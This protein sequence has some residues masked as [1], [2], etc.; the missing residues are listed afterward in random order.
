MTA[1]PASAG[2]AALAADPAQHGRQ[3]SIDFGQS[4]MPGLAEF[5]AG[6]NGEAVEAVRQVCR[7][8]AA[9]TRRRRQC[10][11]LWGPTGTGKTHLLRAVCMALH[12][13]GLP[14]AY[15]E[16]GATLPRPE[17]LREWASHVLLC[18]DGLDRIACNRDWEIALYDLYE[19][20]RE[21]NHVLLAA[22][23]RA[24]ADLP[25]CLPDLAS[26]LGWGLVYRLK[27]LETDGERLEALM[28][29]AR[30]YAFTLPDDVAHYL[31][32]RFPRDMHTLCGLLE[33]ID[34]ASLASGQRVTLRA[35]RAYLAGQS[36]ACSQAERTMGT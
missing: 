12:R 20:T 36:E 13:A 18:I 28:L 8:L 34:G 26:R 33:R 31:L 15:M 17:E 10:L 27:P 3:L 19:R 6:A 16:A 9:P 32:R 21:Q 11:Y 14:T 24:P 22:S 35:V 23:R 30:T 7:L 25:L 1:A 4:R 5:V 2:R 29:R